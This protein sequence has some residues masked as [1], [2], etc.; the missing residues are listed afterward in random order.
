MRS[1]SA[2]MRGPSSA[3]GTKR[4][5]TSSSSRFWRT[6]IQA[7]SASTASSA[8]SAALRVATNLALK[9]PPRIMLLDV[10]LVHAVQLGAAGDVAERAGLLGHE[11]DYLVVRA[12]LGG[13]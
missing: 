11:G 7:L 1:S 5:C 12:Q 10:H 8:N 9:E 2:S 13:R 4:P 6:P 3:F